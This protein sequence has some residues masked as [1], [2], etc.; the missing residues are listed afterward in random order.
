MLKTKR[1]E[2]ICKNCIY[3]NP[4]QDIDY[5][6][7][8]Y[9]DGSICK[10]VGINDTCKHFNSERRK[11]EYILC[12]AIHFEDDLVHAHQPKN[13]LTGVVVCGMRHHNVF[14]TLSALNTDRSKFERLSGIQG[15]IT[16]LNR[17]VDRKEGREIAFNAGQTTKKE[18]DLYSEDLY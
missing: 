2:K 15:F 17:F 8:C 12:A 11:P 5:R 9:F 16:N 1:V 18:G 13:I 14:A 6:G 4:K 7:I 10:F 3:Y